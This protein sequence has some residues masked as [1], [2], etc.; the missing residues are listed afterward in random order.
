MLVMGT[1]QFSDVRVPGYQRP[2]T[3]LMMSAYHVSNRLISGY[4][5]VS[6]NLRGSISVFL[7]FVQPLPLY[8][9]PLK[10]RFS[11]FDQIQ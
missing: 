2:R 6:N 7:I 8:Y 5:L 1:Y 10:L 4:S 9:D 3:K 11:K